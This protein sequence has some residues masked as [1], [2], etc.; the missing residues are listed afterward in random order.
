M[1]ACTHICATA[2]IHTCIYAVVVVVGV[3]TVAGVYFVGR[4]R[5]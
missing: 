4:A 1:S 2:Y 3:A 5:G